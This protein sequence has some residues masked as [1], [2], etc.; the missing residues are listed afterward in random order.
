[1]NI[2]VRYRKYGHRRW[3]KSILKSKKLLFFLWWRTDKGLLNSPKLNYA[4][5]GLRQVSLTLQC[6]RLLLIII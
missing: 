6:E 4:V 3:W 1:M 2:S 5:V